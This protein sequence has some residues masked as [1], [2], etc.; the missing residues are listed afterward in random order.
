MTEEHVIFHFQWFC[1]G[2]CFIHVFHV[3]FDFPEI[4]KSGIFFWQREIRPTLTSQKKYSN[5][6]FWFNFLFSWWIGMSI[7]FQSLLS[8]I[9]YVFDILFNLPE[10]RK[11]RK[12]LPGFSTSWWRLLQRTSEPLRVAGDRLFCNRGRTNHNPWKASA[13]WGFSVDAVSPWTAL[14][15]AVPIQRNTWRNLGGTLRLIAR[16]C[17]DESHLS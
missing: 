17:W 10:S 12:I 3:L 15:A 14:R 13:F 5:A 6:C 9:I 4:E 7:F 11:I 1:S 2:T 16:L 8:T